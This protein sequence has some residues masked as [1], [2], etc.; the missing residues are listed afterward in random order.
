MLECAQADAARVRLAVA[1]AALESEQ[2]AADRA[3]E[4]AKQAREALEARRKEVAQVRAVSCNPVLCYSCVC[5]HARYLS[6]CIYS[7]SDA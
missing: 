6:P 5:L 3:A 1:D 2:L 4:E 7:L